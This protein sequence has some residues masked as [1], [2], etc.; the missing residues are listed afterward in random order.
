MQGC[1]TT[2]A[3]RSL[4]TQPAG[5]K[6]RA[7]TVGI[8]ARLATAREA[9]RLSQDVVADLLGVSRVMVSHWERGQRRP[10]EHT[11]ERLAAVY[12]VPLPVLVDVDV[13][14]PGSSTVPGADLVA[15]L[16][17]DA[18]SGID[19]AAEAGLQDFVR[20]LDAYADL[21]ERLD[22]LDYALTQSPFSIRRGFSG[23]DDVRRK[24]EEVRDWLRLGLGPVGDLAG[25]LDD[26]GITV[27]RTALGAD[28]QRGVSGAFLNHPRLGMSIAVNV[29]T[30]PGRQVFTIAHELAHALYHSQRDS[31][32]VSYWGR[33]DEKERF[34]DAWAGE[35][36]VPEEGLRRASESL[37]IKSVTRADEAVHLQRLF[38]V[39]YGMM[40]VRLL[41]AK[42]L[43]EET[44]E[45]IKGA[46][47]VAL[48]SALGYVVHPEEWRQDPARW[49]L[50][51]F[52]RRFIRALTAA[53]R[54]ERISP[55][56]AAAF[57][58]LTVDEMAE[59]MTPPTGDGDEAAEQE[60]REFAGVRQRAAAA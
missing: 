25:I 27:Y 26:A 38:G 21:L 59:L 46:R 52:P 42:L 4:V 11:L 32:V 47:P 60:Q 24:A 31:Q 34:A 36:L 1:V 12:G 29:E 16:F 3:G 5:R 33:Q 18:Q 43:D 54:D 13:P 8:G 14:L 55:A 7:A 50:E 22:L 19:A 37:G 41:Q 35:F 39:S 30:T 57:T 9:R 58:G 45:E 48:A 15:L 53:L 20:F 40:L 6:E 49:R 56:S 2:I 10:S 44:Y 51:R 17:R 23:R 28:L